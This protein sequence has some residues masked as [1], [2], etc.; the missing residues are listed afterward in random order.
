MPYTIEELATALVNAIIVVEQRNLVPGYMGIYDG[1]AGYNYDAPDGKKWV[2]IGAGDSPAPASAWNR[3][4][5]ADDYTQA[6]WISI[7]PEGKMF[8]VEKRY[9]GY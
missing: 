8:I 4:G 6:I 2:R 9:E 7:N 3:A 5:V 1:A